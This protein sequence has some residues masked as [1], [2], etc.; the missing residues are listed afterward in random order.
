MFT[1]QTSKNNFYGFYIHV[2]KISDY[3]KVNMY[4]IKA[5]KQSKDVPIAILS[6]AS[7]DIFTPR[8]IG[9]KAFIEKCCQESFNESN[10]V[11]KVF[12][13]DVK[14]DKLARQFSGNEKACNVQVSYFDEL[15]KEF[16]AY[17]THPNC[18]KANEEFFMPISLADFYMMND[19]RS[20]KEMRVFGENNELCTLSKTPEFKKLSEEELKEMEQTFFDYLCSFPSEENKKRIDDLGI[21]NPNP[22]VH[23][24]VYNLMV[25]SLLVDLQQ[26]KAGAKAINR[27]W[28]DIAPKYGLE[29]SSNI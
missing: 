4:A 28:K 26:D 11:E 19:F 17:H 10:P 13:Y 22:N 24:D 25:E 15:T 9:T 12:L 2:M 14:K 27:F 6:S 5:L 29:Y 20:V 16:V 7:G 23:N 18:R 1:Y 8:E 21:F 3:A